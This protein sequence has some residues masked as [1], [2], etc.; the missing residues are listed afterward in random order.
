MI[1]EIQGVYW[2]CL[3]PISLGLEFNQERLTT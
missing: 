3:V 1:D 2:I